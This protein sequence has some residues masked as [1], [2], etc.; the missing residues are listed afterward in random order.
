MAKQKSELHPK[1]KHHG[2]YNFE[3]LTESNPELNEY[4]HK[5]KSGRLSIPFHD[6]QAVKSLNKALLYYFYDLQYW[7]IPDGYLCPGVPGRAEYVHYIADL[8]FVTNNKK[9]VNADNIKGID[10]GTGSSCI[11][12]IIAAVDYKWSM[13]GTD[14]DEAAI[15]SAKKI[16]SSNESLKS[17]IDIV[18]QEDTKSIFRNI[19]GADNYFDF[20]MCNPPFF[21]SKEEAL[22]ASER[23]NT[24]LNP[25]PSKSKSN[26]GGTASE[27]WCDGGEYVFVRKMI[28]ESKSF[29]QSSYWF[30][31]LVS[32]I[33]H[34]DPLRSE[35]E[36]LKC[37]EIRVIDI[38]LGNKKTR[39]LCW[40]FLNQKQK[41]AWRNLRW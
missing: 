35:L 23:K 5:A 16:V 8:L 27:L 29:A 34:L 39:I 7:D 40:S 28:H 10:I 1:N 25:N 9:S 24:N 26:F 6:P 41:T 3:K 14:I 36:K 20:T 30:T 17:K 2:D 11:Y 13:V 4:V 38:M 37:E 32:N 33:K 19:L 18:L 12:P 31:S 21:S 22:A 15:Q